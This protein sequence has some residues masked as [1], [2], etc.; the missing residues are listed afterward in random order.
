VLETA[1]CDGYL[2]GFDL[3]TSAG[4]FKP[5]CV[6]MLAIRQHE[7]DALT[8]LTQL[9]QEPLFLNGLT[10]SA[11][12]TARGV[13]TAVTHP[14]E[15]LKRVP[16]GLGRLA[17]GA[18]ARVQEGYTPGETGSIIHLPAKRKLAFDL[19]VDPYTDNAALQHALNSV[20]ANRNYGSLT[21]GIGTAFVGGIVGTG[22]TVAKWNAAAL[23]KLRDH[24][25]PELLVMNRKALADLGVRPRIAEEFLERKGYS[26]TRATV[27]TDALTQ[28]AAVPNINQYPR[29]LLPA[30]RPE[31]ALYYQE[32]ISMAVDHHQQKGALTNLR[33]AAGMAVFDTGSTVTHVFAPV[34][35]I[36]WTPAIETRSQQILAAIGRGRTVHLWIPGPASAKARVGLAQLGVVLHEKTRN[37]L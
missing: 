32:Q 30:D 36:L 34:D 1:E 31:V 35:T 28:L 29:I 21:F 10:S 18:A 6:T 3:W 27:I 19:G 8:S 11:T 15:T 16:V 14:V 20:A 22:I 7:A 5:E 23:D 33:E 26:T 37:H 17:G 24:S 13:K 25:G 9:Q 12:N 4:W 2:F